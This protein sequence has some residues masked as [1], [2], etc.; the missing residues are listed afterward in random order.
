VIGSGGIPLVQADCV[1]TCEE[2][3]TGW[4]SRI[5]RSCAG[6]RAGCRSVAEGCLTRENI[7]SDHRRA[8]GRQRKAE[9]WESSSHGVAT[10]EFKEEDD[11]IE[12]RDVRLYHART[13]LYI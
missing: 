10:E 3:T 11:R 7:R 6:G 13:V 12:S 1:G 5:A 8:H 2:P 9:F 4:W